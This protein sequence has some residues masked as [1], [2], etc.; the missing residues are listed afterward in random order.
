[1]GTKA[2]RRKLCYK[3]ARQKNMNLVDIL[4]SNVNSLY[5]KYIKNEEVFEEPI[6]YIAGA[7]TLP[8]PL[9]E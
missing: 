1:M 6:F 5:V 7:Q 4:K 9:P 2:E 8:P 3:I